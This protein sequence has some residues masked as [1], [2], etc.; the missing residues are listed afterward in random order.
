MSLSI[1]VPG[2]VLWLTLELIVGLEMIRLQSN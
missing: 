1:R 2:H